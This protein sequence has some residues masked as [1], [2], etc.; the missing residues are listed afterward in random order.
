MK[1]FGIASED[2]NTEKLLSP[3]DEPAKRQLDKADLIIL[4]HY[5]LYI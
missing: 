5:L 1:E 3:S 2:Q 4:E